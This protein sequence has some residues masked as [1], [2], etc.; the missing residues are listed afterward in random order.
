MKKILLCLLIMAASASPA[1]ALRA[2]I[3]VENTAAVGVDTML[4]NIVTQYLGYTVTYFDID[5]I[6]SA[7]AT[8]KSSYFD[9]AFDVMILCGTEAA[10]PTPTAQA[11]S[12][13]NAPVGVVAI[14]QDFWDET[15]LGTATSNSNGSS[16]RFKNL[17]T[18]HWITRVFTDTIQMHTAEA[19]NQ[20][21]IATPDSI[22]S[23]GIIPLLIGTT[24]G[25]DTS[26][27]MAVAADSGARI[28]GTSGGVGGS[29]IAK[30]RRVFC[31][32]FQQQT[33]Q[34]DSCQFTTLMVRAIAWAAKDTLNDLMM[35]NICFSGRYELDLAHV[36]ENSSGTDS[37]ECYGT[38]S[39][40]NL[41]Q[42]SEEK[43]CFIKIKNSAMQRK[44]GSIYRALDVSR[45]TLRFGYEGTSFQNSGIY[46][47]TTFSNSITF[48]PIIRYWQTAFSSV[49]IHSATCPN[50]CWTYAW[51]DTA[52]NPDVE[53]AWG[54]G[55][56]RQYDVD[57][58]DL[59]YD[60]LTISE[61]TP[62]H[63]F[64]TIDLH[65]DTLG[66]RMLDTLKN[67][68]WASRM[69]SYAAEHDDPVG[70]A[71]DYGEMSF[72]QVGETNRISGMRGLVWPSI[73][74]LL[75]SWSTTI[76]TPTI[77]VAT[78]SYD[79]DSVVFVGT[80][81]QTFSPQDVVLSNSQGGALECATISDNSGGWLYLVASG[82][83]MPITLNVYM[84]GQQVGYRS[85]TVTITCADASNSP[86]TFKVV[87]NLV[88]ASAR[89]ATGK[90]IWR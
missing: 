75:S 32:F 48:Q 74:V 52:A 58:R 1:F 25:G 2:A 67:F 88:A 86:R 60:T 36:V 16:G 76:P 20:Y 28:F 73:S 90:E 61:T 35:K 34:P 79:D 29:H 6:G 49:C 38:Y 8:Y 69:I 5:N 43:H 65:P 56:A 82:T 81:G 68:G 54:I 4:Y 89:G 87:S 21:G 22:S 18:A 64:Q 66:T 3:V 33:Y 70:D 57:T 44:I 77:A 85:A 45:A 59:K 78:P 15:N 40:L 55:G 23:T 47:P 51:R 10:I 50:A 14:G 19:I 41:G 53:Y 7:A 83:N 9:T 13:C 72:Y 17:G 46:R 39:G 42:D 63:T 12:I 30:G 11:D 27:C 24:Y 84:I 31:G 80:Y 37:I 62:T 26:R 71:A